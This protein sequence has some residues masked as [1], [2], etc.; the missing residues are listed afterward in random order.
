MPFSL[1]RDPDIYGIC[2]LKSCRARFEHLFYFSSSRALLFGDSPIGGRRLAGTAA[3][4]VGS[5]RRRCLR[6]AAPSAAPRLTSGRW[7][8]PGE[9]SVVLRAL[10]A[11]L[12][13][14][15]A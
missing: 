1:D 14:A 3:D 10:A 5:L 13:A 7:L 15:T 4:S 9:T 2:A 6:S 8:R 11:R 12:A